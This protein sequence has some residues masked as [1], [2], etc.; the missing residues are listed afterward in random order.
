MSLDL[1]ILEREIGGSTEAS[2]QPEAQQNTIERIREKLAKRLYDQR[3]E[4]PP[5]RPVYSLAGVPICTPGNLATI[6]A[7]AKTG[8]SAFIGSMIAAALKPEPVE[9]DTLGLAAS[10]ERGLALLHFD[11]EQSPDDHWHHNR[12]AEGRAKCA[13]RPDWLLSY[14]LTGM[15]ALEASEAVWQAVVDAAEKFGGVHSILL[16]GVADLVCDVNDSEECNRFVAELHNL[17]IKYDC[18][19]IGVIHFNPGSE[20][21]RGHLGSQLERKA[22]TNLVLEKNDQTTAIW[23]T[24]QRRAP[25][26]KAAAPRFH[27]DDN[28]GMHVSCETLESVR[29]SEQAEQ[30]KSEVEDVFAGRPSMRYG[31]LKETTVNRLKL[32]ERAAERRIQKWRQLD[33]VEKTLA[34]LWVKK[35]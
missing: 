10:N 5:L 34:G 22:E 7:Q 25:I 16:D 20:K 29:F 23:S 33:V 2:G 12:R 18:P 1:S 8:K 11:T 26:P 4:P 28:A 35:S 27:W 32:K 14:C 6:T 17:A 24:K 19:I 31:D 9:A 21:S 30:A 3:R 15:S 13:D